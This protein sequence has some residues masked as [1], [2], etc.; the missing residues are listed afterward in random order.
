MAG[1][2][3][4]LLL[5]GWLDLI[6]GVEVRVYPLYFLPVALG[7]WSHGRRAAVALSLT[8]TV[9]WVMSNRQA[10]LVYSHP[11]IWA[12][13]SLAQLMGFSVIGLLIA[14]LHR[15]LQAEAAL[16]RT[17]TLTGLANVR[18]FRDQ[19]AVVL[20]LARRGGRSTTLV[21]VDLDH[22]KAVN[23]TRGHAAGDQVL[24][25]T[26][27]CLREAARATDLAAR[28][29]GDEFALLLPETNAE[30][31][32]AVLDRFRTRLAETMQRGGWHVTASIGAV[33]FP[34]AP[35]EPAAALAAAD[36]QMYLAKQAGRDRCTIEVLHSPAA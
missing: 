13:N 32:R 16:S 25:A 19:L 30:G 29:G 1:A 8:A 34:L 22:F 18:A 6:T 27:A 26:A 10:G 28:L 15:R 23:D 21:Y 4:G 2:A 33:V 9:I 17:D 36:A 31:A 11:A 14:E 12:I 35:A 7:A 24:R 3:V 5:V 20:G